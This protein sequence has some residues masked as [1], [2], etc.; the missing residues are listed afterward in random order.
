[1]RGDESELKRLNEETFRAEAKQPIRGTTWREYL[2]ELL[3]ETFV[4]RR[5][6]SDRENEDKAAML[7]AIDQTEDPPERT[8][9]PDTVRVWISETVGV[10]ASTVTL[11]VEGETK[12]FA[13]VKVFTR[14]AAGTW[15]CV[16]WQVSPRP[17]PS[18]P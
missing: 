5:S 8:L 15:R 7:H 13:N 17:M 9:L 11:P 2:T 6:R 16:Y 18:N 3:D 4:L 1:V 10:V 12:A 14:P